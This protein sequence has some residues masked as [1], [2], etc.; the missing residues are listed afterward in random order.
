[1]LDSSHFNTWLPNFLLPAFAESEDTSPFGSSEHNILEEEW[2]MELPED[3]DM[4]IA[5]RNFEDAVDLV[6]KG[7]P[8]LP[9]DLTV[10]GFSPWIIYCLEKWPYLPVYP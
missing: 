8:V 4:L 9:K 10:L 7:N 1:M 5:Q 3:L 6:L 2:V